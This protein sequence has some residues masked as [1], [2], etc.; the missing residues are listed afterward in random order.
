MGRMKKETVPVLPDHPFARE[1]VIEY[2]FE[3][4]SH[5]RGSHSGGGEPL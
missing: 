4:V 5:F 1:I 3:E 2:L